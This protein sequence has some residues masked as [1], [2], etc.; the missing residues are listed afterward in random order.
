M[1]TLAWHDH[2]FV[3]NPDGK[4]IIG[5]GYAIANGSFLVAI[6]GFMSPSADITERSKGC[7][8]K[9]TR[10]CEVKHG[11]GEMMEHMRGHSEA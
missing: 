6:T 11:E 1:E 3:T 7:I 8:I 10:T 5:A 9:R 2:S 4:F